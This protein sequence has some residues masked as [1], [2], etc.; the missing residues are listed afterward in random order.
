MRSDMEYLGYQ[1]FCEY[2]DVPDDRTR[3][4]WHIVKDPKGKEIKGANWGPYHNVSYEEFKQFVID[5][6][7]TTQGELDYG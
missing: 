3:K 4:F 1:Y 7:V 6:C 5:C 2:D